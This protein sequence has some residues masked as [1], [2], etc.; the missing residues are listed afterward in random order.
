AGSLDL[1]GAQ[2]DAKVHL[3]NCYLPGT[4]DISDCS[5][6]SIRLRG[7]DVHRLRAARCRVEGLLDL[8]GTTVHQGV[9]L[10]NAHVAG[11][12]RLSH[13]RRY[14]RLEESSAGTRMVDM[15]TP[16]SAQEL[17]DRGHDHWALWAGGL[18]VDGGAFLREMRIIG[19]IRLPGARF[20]GGLNMRGTV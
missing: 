8:D 1:S 15:Y 18:T 7:C 2:L 19:G 11:Q 6:R 20:L 13:A 5:T 4:V 10:D 12:L 16:Y 9:R 3:L 14:R 17:A